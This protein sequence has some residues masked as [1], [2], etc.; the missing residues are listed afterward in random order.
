MALSYI[1]ATVNVSLGSITYTADDQLETSPAYG[2]LFQSWT[3]SYLN[4]PGDLSQISSLLSDSYAIYVPELN[5]NVA[6]YY[7]DVQNPPYGGSSWNSL[8]AGA[9]DIALTITFN[10]VDDFDQTTYDYT[11]YYPQPTSYSISLVPVTQPIG[12]DTVSTITVPVT[13]TQDGGPNEQNPGTQTF[14]YVSQ[15]NEVV[16]IF[17]QLFTTGSDTVNFNQFPALEAEYPGL[18]IAGDPYHGLGGSDTVTLPD[19]ANYN[20]P[21]GNGSTLGWTDTLRQHS[22]LN[23]AREIRIRLT[24][25]TELT[26]VTLLLKERELSS[27]RLTATAPTTSPPGQASI[28]SRLPGTVTTRSPVARA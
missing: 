1:V 9:F 15:V 18:V 4:T 5:S 26:K 2:Q 10:G 19:E 20:A 23:L 28:I 21:L 27:L 6:I 7:P 17:D 24:V 16:G 11:L 3:D 13:E 8:V 12:T 14:P 25:A 22:T